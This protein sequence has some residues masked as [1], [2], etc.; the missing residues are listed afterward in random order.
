MRNVANVGAYLGSIGATIP[1]TN[2]ARCL[3]G[4]YD[5]KHIDVAPCVFTNTLPT[6]PYRGAGRPEASYALERLVDEAA[7]VTGIDP[8]KLRRRNL[9]KKSAMPYK[10]AVGTTYDSGDFEPILDKAL[11]LADYAGFKQRRR[12]IAEARQIARPRHLLLARTFRR[13][14]ARE[15]A[16]AFPGNDTLLLR[17]NV[18]NTGQGHATVFPRLIADAPRH[19]AGKDRRT[20]T[21][22]Q[23]L[24]CRATPRSARVRP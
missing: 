5:I 10:T 20:A 1:T 6:A 16:A 11:E 3:P 21:A 7:R 2:F 13:H 22:I 19:P 18:Q 15:R 14:A 8:I 17:L 12:E 24:N 9:I 23:R 4:M